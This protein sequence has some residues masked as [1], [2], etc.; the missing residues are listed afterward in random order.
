MD[1]ETIIDILPQIFLSYAL[2]PKQYIRSSIKPTFQVPSANT[3]FQHNSDMP[4]N[5]FRRN[6]TKLSAESDQPPAYDSISEDQFKSLQKY[7]TVILLDDSGSMW[8]AD[9][10]FAKKSRWK[11]VSAPN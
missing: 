9:N 8:G 2:L 10:I 6:R 11:L 3:V 7:D 4:L 5:L 1:V